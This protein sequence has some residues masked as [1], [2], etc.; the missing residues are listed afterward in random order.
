SAYVADVA[1]ALPAP[2]STGAQGTIPSATAV[3]RWRQTA[4]SECSERGSCRRLRAQL[5]E[6][7]P[8]ALQVLEIEDLPRDR[9]ASFEADQIHE[10]GFEGAA[11]R[12][13]A[14]RVAD[15]QEPVL[16]TRDLAQRLAD[17]V[18]TLLEER[19]RPCEVCVERLQSAGPAAAVVVIHEIGGQDGANS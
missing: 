3:A 14:E 1:P 7:C 12:Q 6:A 9:S 19:A 5:L 2:R 18:G 11:L 16:P 4:L 13:R 8:R 17:R 15:E 10:Y